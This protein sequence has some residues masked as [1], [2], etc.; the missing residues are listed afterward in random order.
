M[1]MLLRA[2]LGL[3]VLLVAELPAQTPSPL[4][5][6]QATAATMPGNWIVAESRAYDALQAGFP[7][8]AAAGY[9]EILT[10]PALPADAR[11]RMTLALV[12]AL[13]DA[14][15]LNEAERALQTFDGLRGSAY[16]VRAGLLAATQRRWPQA[17]AALAASKPE[18]VSGTDRGWWYFLQAMVAESD[19]DMARRDRAYDEAN[20]AAVSEV[21][22]ARFQ[23]GQ[24]QARLRTEVPT[25]AQLATYRSNMER[26][27]GTQSGYNWVRTY[28]SALNRAERKTEALTVLQRQLALLPAT[29]RNTA[30]QF[31]LLLG[32][33]AGEDSPTGRKALGELVAQG[34][35]PE[36]QRT[37]LYLLARGAR[38][39]AT[40]EE[41]RRRLSELI[42]PSMNHPIIEDLLLA[43]AHAALADQQYSDADRDAGELLA[44][45]PGSP[46]KAGALGVRLA[47]TWERGRYRAAADLV[48]QIRTTQL[49][50]RERS[51]LG[52]LLAEAF[53][54]AGDYQSAADA[55]DAALRE[56]PQV[57]SAGKLIFQRVL[58]DI[59][60]DRL[61][62]ASK[63]LDE[64]TTNPSFDA[65]SRWQA[66]WNLIKALQVRGQTQVAL[67]R[68]EKV[69]QARAPDAAA[70]TGELR[71]RL[72]WVRAKLSF[73]SDQFDV[74]IRQVD[75]LLAAL[76]N[77][78]LD[79]ALRSEVASTGVLV[80]AQ[81]LFQL[82]RDDE[83]SKLLDQM[84]AEYKAT[85]AA[86]Y[87]YIVQASNYSEKGETVKA[88]QLLI[89]LKD[90]HPESEYAPLA[91]YEAA[92]CAE[93]RGLETYLSE[94]YRL[95][96]DGLVRK[97][98]ND[99][100]VF[101]A[102]LKQG[103]LLRKLNDFGAARQIYE[104][105]INNQ[106]QHPDVL[107]AQ[108]ALADCLFA[109][110]GNSV[111]NYESAAA[112]Y[113]RLRDLPSAPIDL[114]VEAG[115]K[116][117]YALAK[118]GQGAKAQTVFWSVVDSFLLDAAQASKLGSKGRWWLSRTLLELGQLL[119]DAN[120]LDEAQRA[121]RLV[122]DQNLSGAAL[123]Q[124]KLARFRAPETKGQP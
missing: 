36:T 2:T 84:R 76:P 17:K 14:G 107:L 95:L 104:D 50:G 31:R 93:R 11:Q 28:A 58:S 112:I 115:Y 43:R 37:A 27:Q 13:M 33:I 65:E 110:G 18:E 61:E 47:V 111:V 16:Q 72:L 88:Q 77:A 9:R 86:V 80:K 102:R 30:D 82:K 25:E 62:A 79:T 49:P 73:D 75:E 51:E 106:S 101:Y 57:V 122:L 34:Q 91:V 100:L 117:G 8:T 3:A 99:E 119:E 55:Y 40:R 39:P 5:S 70:P 59:R 98:P 7:A 90:D 19:N 42:T 4:V 69:L 123:A 116:W 10:Q 21:Q 29:E 22:R 66:E 24:E 87:S 120:R 108:L 96:E 44:R 109:Q 45:F 38:T 15:D 89:K 71:V 74:A 94:A 85:K 56:A 46:L 26:F 48:T 32:M 121:Y 6:A 35:R 68:V 92:L 64:M 97:Y 81:A 41:L 54:R 113:E 67:A 83:A 60:A 78:G 124:S 103:D 118:R 12:S 20:R 53:F 52:V 63:L 114:R 23:L 105:L 1:K